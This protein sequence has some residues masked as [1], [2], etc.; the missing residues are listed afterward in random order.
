[1]GGEDKALRADFNI[2]KIIDSLKY[3]A[4]FEPDVIFS[5]SGSIKTNATQELSRKIRFLENMAEKVLNLHSKGL[6]V[7]EIRNR[8]VGPELLIR[9]ITL[10]HYSG[11]NL[12]NSFI[13][14]KP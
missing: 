1:M 14:H 4:T 11:W 10:G 6:S 5:G 12:I 9:Y 7:T 3:L 2:W 8:V 13:I